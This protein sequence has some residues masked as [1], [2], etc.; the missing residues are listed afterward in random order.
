MDFLDT[1]GA[2]S[3]GVANTLRLALSSMA[4]GL[5]GGTALALAHLAAGPRTR[6]ALRL[7]THAVQSV[8]HLVVIFMAMFGLP[9]VGVRLPPFFTVVACLGLVASAY[10]GEVLRGALQS[11]DPLQREA[12][13]ALGFS[14]RQAFRHVLAP[15]MWRLAVPG[16]LN[17][18]TSVLKATPFAYVAGVPEI[19]KEAHALT[20][21]T[22]RGLPVYAAAALLFLSLY[23]ACNAL[24]R[25]LCRRFQIPGFEEF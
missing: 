21:V 18:F 25:T 1:F 20:A 6:S 7:A 8:P 10:V 12:A 4:V 23:L 9:L 19:L 11:I 24:V 13:V 2:L 16:L 17:E 5:A 22:S 15:Q 14:S 3:F